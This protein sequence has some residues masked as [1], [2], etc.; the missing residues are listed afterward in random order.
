MRLPKFGNPLPARKKRLILGQPTQQ[1][2]PL[3]YEFAW[4][5][6]KSGQVNHWTPEDIPLGD[7]R[8]QYLN[9]L[10]EAE[11]QMFDF[12]LAMLTTQDLVVM[13][14]L[15]EGIEK[16]LTAPE[17]SMYLARQTDEE[18]I[19][20][21]S[22]QWIVESLALDP[23][24]VYE[25][26][27]FEKSIYDKVAYSYGWHDRLTELELDEQKPGSIGEF[28]KCMAFWTLGM[29]GGWFYNGF[30]WVY[31]LRRRNL[32][33]GSAEIFKYIQRDEALHFNFW[34]QVMQHIIMEFPG[35]FTTDVQE[36]IRDMAREVVD[37]EEA[38]AVAACS[39]VFGISAIEYMNHFK[40]FMDTNLA[41]LNL[42][43][44]FN[45]TPLSWLPEVSEINQETNFFEGRVREYQKGALDWSK[46]KGEEEG[47]GDPWDD[48]V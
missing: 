6:F 18:A 7:D 43:P 30:N 2:F 8:R 28:L 3:K 22:Y 45:G 46:E 20:T 21:W 34:I 19:H 24:S 39:G 9:K 47:Q 5:A 38:Y 32:M 14:N 10:T 17:A 12:C 41:K 4:E 37:L 44:I 11:A 33:Q 23:N 35:V 16:H 36:S 40:F 25:K 29:E 15:E 1:L 13:G 42:D 26:Y 31:A 27:L 48:V